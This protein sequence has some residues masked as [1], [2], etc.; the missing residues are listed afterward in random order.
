MGMCTAPQACWQSAPCSCCRCPA[1]LV[2]PPWSA[3]RRMNGCAQETLPYV[4]RHPAGGDTHR[5][6]R[7]ITRDA[8]PGRLYR[9][10]RSARLRSAGSLPDAACITARSASPSACVHLARAHA[11]PPERSAAGLYHPGPAASPPS[12]R[13]AIRSALSHPVSVLTGGPGT[14]KTTALRALIA[15]LEAG[16]QALCPGLA[17]RAGCQAPVGGHRAPCQHHPPPAGLLPR[18]GLQAQPGEPAAGRPA[19]GGRGLHA[20]PDPGEQP[21]QG[22]RSRARTCCWWAMWTSCPRW[23][24]AMCCAM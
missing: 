1:E 8:P 7:P 11:L 22:A 23:G 5:W 21:A 19:G 17:H 12:R 2:P 14:G 15:A 13:I 10:A 6:S 9:S 18:R 20:R 16:G 3:W 4:A 24:R